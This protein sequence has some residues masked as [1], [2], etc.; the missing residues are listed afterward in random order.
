MSAP[1]PPPPPAE[2]NLSD[3]FATKLPSVALGSR[4]S[5]LRR[6]AVFGYMQIINGRYKTNK[7]AGRQGAGAE[8][9]ALH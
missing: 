4:D 6:V 3:A 8:S 9:V 1:A 5:T 7:W 2:R